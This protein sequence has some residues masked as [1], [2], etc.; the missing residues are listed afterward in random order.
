[1]L[2]VRTRKRLPHF[3][4]EVDFAVRDEILVL[5]GP[6]GAG[7]T[8]TLRMIAGLERPDAGEIRLNDR[9]LYSREGRAWV[10]PRARR[11]GFV[12]QDSAL[13]PHLTVTGNVLYG[14]RANGDTSARLETLLERFRITH[15]AG[16]YPSQLSGGEVQRVALARALMAD[17]D[18]LL[19]DEPF[20]SLDADTRA[21]AQ[22]VVLDAHQT[23]RIPFV[24]VTHDRAEAGRVGDRMLFL[25]EGRQVEDG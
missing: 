16:R 5:F 8:M 15:L 21:A 20:S 9:V 18:V 23:W 7:K 11:C 3:T 19:L 4:L 25:R 14:A 24:F 22:D 1:M 2:T 6:S 12:F 13:F 17:P 10:P